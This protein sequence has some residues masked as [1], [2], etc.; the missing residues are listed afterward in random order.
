M[1]SKLVEQLTRLYPE[2]ADLHTPSL[3]ELEKQ[4]LRE[5]VD[6]TF[7]STV[8]PMTV[9]VERWLGAY[10]GANHAV[11]TSNGTSA[12]HLCLHVLGVGRDDLVI[13]PTMTFVATANA[14]LYTGARCLFVDVEPERLACNPEKLRAF[15][16]RECS[17]TNGRCVFTRTGEQ[18]RALVLVHLF[19]IPAATDEIQDICAAFGIDLVEDAAEALGSVYRG[20]HVGTFGRLAALSFNGNKIVT[21]GGGGAVLTDDS[22][23]QARL[24]HLSTTAKA[25]QDFTFY[26]DEMGFNYRMPN[27]NAALLVAQLE[28]LAEMLSQK[29]ALHDRYLEVLAEVEEGELQ[30]CPTDSRSNYWLNNFVLHPQFVGRHSE[31]LTALNQAQ[32]RVRPIWNLMHTLPYLEGMPRMEDLSIAEDYARRVI[33]LPSS[34]HLLS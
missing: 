12:L 20:R 26:H 18:I 9:E 22:Q 32:I 4:R 16:R 3:G 33:S 24:K 2:G 34:A 6:S 28:R 19:G 13:V 11:V 17:V 25:S 10:T 7:V 29:R 1:S 23:L 8:G 27:L 5:C 15:L 31:L 21:A 14:V 30:R